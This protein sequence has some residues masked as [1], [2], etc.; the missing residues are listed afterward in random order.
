M[1]KITEVIAELRD[2]QARL[3]LELSRIERVLEVLE[4]TLAPAREERV[5]LAAPAP[6]AEAPPSERKYA[7]WVHPF[8]VQYRWSAAQVLEISLDL[9]P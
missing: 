5:A 7:E 3:K 4:A 2:E 9:R 1:S 8:V 6:A